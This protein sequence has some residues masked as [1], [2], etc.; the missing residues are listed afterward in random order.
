MTSSSAFEEKLISLFF[1]VNFPCAK[2]P[3]TPQKRTN[4]TN[5]R[6]KLKPTT[7]LAKDIKIGYR[8]KAPRA[9]EC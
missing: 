2:A 3:D 1:T 8:N 9:V 6:I 5:T 7:G 4:Q